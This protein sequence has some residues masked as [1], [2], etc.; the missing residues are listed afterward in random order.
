MSH[1][2]TEASQYLHAG[3][4]VVIP[5]ETVY[6]LAADAT[7]DHAVA[8]IFTIKERPTFNPLIVHVATVEAASMLVQFNP[9][10]A[11]LA[12]HFWPG[13]L[14]LVLPKQPNSPLS[15]L[16][17]TGL[18]TIAI[19]IPA[20]P[21][22]LELLQTFGKPLAAPS[23]NR[24]N[25]L[26]PTCAEDVRASLDP[27]A[28]LI[29]DAGPCTVGIE[30]TI[31]D[32]SHEQPLI[33]RPGGI[34]TERLTALLGPVAYASTEEGIRAPGMMK[35]HYAPQTPLRLNAVDKQANELMLGF[36]TAPLS[37]LNLSATGDL[38]EAAAN[39]FRMLRELDIR[40]AQRIAVMP[41]P[42]RG[43]GIAINDRLQRAS[44][45]ES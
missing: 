37:D 43:L 33:L 40:G 10:A 24:S 41:I 7:N 9:I 22:T 16:V 21:V 4:C 17:S 11:K 3:Q 13:P 18:D 36:G 27:A 34:E 19:R 38:T 23:A 42:M 31:V 5:T 12:K 25:T 39:L 44:A 28:P 6:G 35:R 32:L 30:S 15:Y 26:S 2:L 20:H 1:V 14:T 8:Q 45:S 29:I